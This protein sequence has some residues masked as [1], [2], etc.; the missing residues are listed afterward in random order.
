MKKPYIVILILVVALVAI[1]IIYKSNH[2]VELKTYHNERQGFEIGVPK[3]SIPTIVT[4]VEASKAKNGDFIPSNF[5]ATYKTQGVEVLIRKNFNSEIT[6]HF[7]LGLYPACRTEKSVIVNDTYTLPIVAYSSSRQANETSC[8]DDVNDA[9]TVFSRFCVSDNGNVYTSEPSTQ[10]SE[11][12][13]E[14]KG[15]FDSEFNINIFCHGSNWQGIV[16]RDKCISLYS[17]I[18]QSFKLY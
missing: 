15:A 3:N 1:K 2:G 14:C 6:P 9:H 13:Y 12:S 4:D 16:G 5:S 17:K 18:I 10:G 7:L 8:G 11:A